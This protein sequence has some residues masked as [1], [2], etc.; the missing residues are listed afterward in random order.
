MGGELA[1]RHFSA[2]IPFVQ[3]EDGVR[4]WLN[5]RPACCE[6]RKGRGLK[7][8]HGGWCLVLYSALNPRQL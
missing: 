2:R 8:P 4:I 3:W 1:R 5:N 6:G 7:G